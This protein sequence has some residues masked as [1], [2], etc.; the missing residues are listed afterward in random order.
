MLHII[1]EYR[2]GYSRD[3]KWSQQECTCE[4]LEQ[5]KDFYGL[6][7]DPSCEWRILKIEPA[8]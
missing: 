4:S 1:F 2:D 7:T 6:G 3:G 5:C 8:K